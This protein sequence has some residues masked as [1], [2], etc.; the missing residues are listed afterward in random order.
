MDT[1]VIRGQGRAQQPKEQHL[2][3]V[4]EGGEAEVGRRNVQ[5]A[6]APCT[7]IHALIPRQDFLLFAQPEHHLRFPKHTV[8]IVRKHDVALV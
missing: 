1:G 3:V 7:G 8:V 5:A 4:A 6:P 2:K